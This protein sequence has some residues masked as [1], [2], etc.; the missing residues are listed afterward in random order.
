MA[1]R[2]LRRSAPPVIVR[3]YGRDSLLVWA[4]LLLAPLFGVLGLRIGL[5][6][7]EQLA[8][9]IEADATKMGKRGYLV[10][11]AETFTPARRGDN[12]RG[13]GNQW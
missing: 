3:E 6:S 9:R 12:R 13:A 10:A 8:A 11:S 2:L 5:Q 4:N 1:L 7:E